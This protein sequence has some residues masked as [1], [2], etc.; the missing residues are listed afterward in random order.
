MQCLIASFN[1]RIDPDADYLCVFSVLITICL[2]FY[3]ILLY[4]CDCVFI[5]CSDYVEIANE[6]LGHYKI[7]LHDPQD[8]RVTLSTES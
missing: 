6:F 3:C 4:S 2:L 7:T 8:L 1:C 5:F